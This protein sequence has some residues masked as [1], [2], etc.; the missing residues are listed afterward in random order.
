MNYIYLN[1][2]KE[3]GIIKENFPYFILVKADWDDFGYKTSYNLRYYLDENETHEIGYIKIL[4]LSKKETELSSRFEQLSEDYISLGQSLDFYKNLRKFF[5][6]TVSIILN[7]LRDVISNKE[8]GITYQND[9]G[10]RYSLLRYTSAEKVYNYK[11]D[12]LQLDEF[13]SIENFSFTYKTRIR[14]ASSDHELS[15][16]LDNSKDSPFRTLVLIGKNGT[17][18][19]AFLSDFAFSLTGADITPKFYPHRPLFSKILVISFSIFDT[20]EPPNDNGLYNYKLISF[21]DK[22]GKKIEDKIN[23]LLKRSINQIITKKRENLCFRIFKN[24]LDLEL[25]NFG[26]NH[27]EIVNFNSLKM[28]LETPNE[29]SSGQNIIVYIVTSLIANLEKNSILLIDEPETHLHPNGIE[30]LMESIYQLLDR[31]RSFAV[32]ST[33]SPIVLQETPSQNV[34]IFDRQGTEPIISRLAKESFGENLSKITDYIFHKKTN[35]EYYKK[36]LENKVKEG[37]NDDEISSLF[38]NDL[39]LNARLFISA[40]RKSIEND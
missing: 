16:T 22:K 29:F 32:I 30:L 35:D 39:S 38:D 3:E 25:F 27:N 9:D 36:Y 12:I 23:T 15:F 26:S 8:L 19:T 11:E 6:D 40:Y 20:F 5:P 18:K 1:P 17:G 4:Q 13:K 28:L 7:N 31:F 10:F 21:K 14:N 34:R 2:S 33:H 37:L 24:V